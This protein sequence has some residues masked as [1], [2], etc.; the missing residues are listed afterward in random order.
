MLVEEKLVVEAFRRQA[1]KRRADLARQLDRIDEILAGHFIIDAECKPAH[2]P[3][4]L[5]L[6][7]AMPAGDRKGDALFCL[8]IVVGDGAGLYVMLHDG[9]IKHRA[10]T[11]A[12]REERRVARRALFAQ[13]GQHNRHD[14]VE[15][16][17][18]A[19]QRGVEFSRGVIVR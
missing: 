16:F 11:R 6:Q 15:P 9:H 13:A 2:R 7:F 17:Q 12:D 4:R 5:P 14:G 10:C 8:G 18:H 19:Q 1:A 3:V